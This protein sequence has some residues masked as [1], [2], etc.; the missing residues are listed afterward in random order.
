MRVTRMVDVMMRLEQ[1]TDTKL[2][3]KPFLTTR[4]RNG[5]NV[6]EK[7]PNAKLYT[8]SALFIQVCLFMTDR[9]GTVLKRQI[10]LITLF[11]VALSPGDH[12]G[13]NY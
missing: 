8:E 13:D 3:L 4:D 9:I 6:V 10:S 11:M 5:Y 12:K 1:R 7:R 2:P